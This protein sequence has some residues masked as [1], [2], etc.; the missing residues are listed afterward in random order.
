LR[1]C[2]KRETGFKLLIC[3]AQKPLAPRRRT[4]SM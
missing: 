3:Y 2:E 1:E 4:V